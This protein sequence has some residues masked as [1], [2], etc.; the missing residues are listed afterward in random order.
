[1]TILPVAKMRK[2]KLSPE[3]TF[4]K[5]GETQKNR[6]TEKQKTAL[7]QLKTKRN[8]SRWKI[9]SSR[10]FFRVGHKRELLWHDYSFLKEDRQNQVRGGAD[11]DPIRARKRAQWMHKIYLLVQAKLL[12]TASSFFHKGLHEC[13][14]DGRNR[15]FETPSPNTGID[16]DES[17][18]ILIYILADNKFF[19]AFGHPSSSLWSWIGCR[20]F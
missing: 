16:N 10:L 5:K 12:H 6:K 2:A 7:S 18:C 14:V 13:F 15:L 17:D 9:H 4:T 3:I 8:F 19:V 11:I 1:M 20:L